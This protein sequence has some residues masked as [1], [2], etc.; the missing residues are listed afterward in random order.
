MC[1]HAPSKSVLLPA[2]VERTVSMFL[3]LASAGLEERRQT[4]NQDRRETKTT[5]FQE[6]PGLRGLRKL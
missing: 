4:I 1:L 5:D 2:G 3:V 6:N